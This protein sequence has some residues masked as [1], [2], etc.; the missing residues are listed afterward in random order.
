MTNV[1]SV[2]PC[3]GAGWRRV[4]G[5][6]FSVV[7][8]WLLLFPNMLGLDCS[9]LVVGGSGQVCVYEDYWPSSPPGW[10]SCR[11]KADKDTVRDFHH[12]LSEH[13]E[14]LTSERQQDGRNDKE[15]AGSLRSLWGNMRSG[16]SIT[17][18]LTALISLLTFFHFCFS[19]RLDLPHRLTHF[20]V[21]FHLKDSSISHTNASRRQRGS[22]GSR[23]N[24]SGWSH[25]AAALLV[26]WCYTEAQ[27]QCKRL[28]E[29]LTWSTG[30]SVVTWK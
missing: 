15:K 26:K 20:S 10:G 9:L 4:C 23:L 5:R 3:Q 6:C 17:R 29:K 16:W 14:P 19:L 18:F 24:I 22:P 7:R 28:R 13:S 25:S 12:L 1:L 30:L 27:W 2:S 11:K 21:Y 8:R